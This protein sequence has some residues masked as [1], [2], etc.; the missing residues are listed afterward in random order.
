MFVWSIEGLHYA[1]Y[2]DMCKSWWMQ[3]ESYAIMHSFKRVVLY[4]Q[5]RTGSY[6]A[7]IDTR[8]IFTF[9]WNVVH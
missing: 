8:P 9:W 1:H 6:I 3:L 2:G 7:N 5:Y 4:F